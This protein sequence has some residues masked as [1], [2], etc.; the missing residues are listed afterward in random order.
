VIGSRLQTISPTDR[1]AGEIGRWG[2]ELGQLYR[3]KGVA[4]DAKGRIFVSDSTTAVVQ[5]FGPRGALEG[6]LTDKDGA[7]LRFQHPMGLS[8]DRKGQLYVVELAANRVAVVSLEAE[9]K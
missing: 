2:I 5:V 1:W 3:P 4:A 8:F 7:P 9:K 6:V